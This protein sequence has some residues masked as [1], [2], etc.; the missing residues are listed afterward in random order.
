[1]YDT[2]RASYR[3]HCPRRGG[4][5]LT[6]VALSAFRRLERLPGAA[7]PAV[8]RIVYD[9][10]CGEA[11]QGLVTHADL[12]YGPLAPVEVEF[13]NLLTGRN[14][15]VGDE[16]AE[17][18]SGQVQRGNWPWQLY[19]SR[20]ARLKPVWPSSLAMVAP[21]ETRRDEFVGVAVVC[22]SC[23]EVSLN[24]VSGTHL[25]VPFYH[26]PVVRYVDRPFGDARDLTVDW[27][28]GQLHSAR[29]D[30]ERATLR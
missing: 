29:F 15:P 24:L 14:E 1:M 7:H 8:Y 9:C 20:E 10:P 13:T 26:D 2:L 16:L 19:C 17:L 3:F 6:R 27:F 18:A 4:D 28:H 12:D 21:A 5:G 25:D 11:H 23:G 30:A 22:P